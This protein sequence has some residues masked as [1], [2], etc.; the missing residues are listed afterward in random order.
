MK[1]CLFIIY[2]VSRRQPLELI[3][4]NNGTQQMHPLN[5]HLMYVVI[6]DI[7]R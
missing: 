1:N 7:W 5:N 2:K 6:E 3:Q 4:I